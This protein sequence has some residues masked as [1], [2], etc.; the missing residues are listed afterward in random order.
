MP[1][2]PQG[3][4]HVLPGLHR[5]LISALR[6]AQEG[7]GLPGEWRPGVRR[8]GE[9]PPVQ[10]GTGERGVLDVH[11]DHE[12]CSEGVLTRRAVAGR[13]H[14]GDVALHDMRASRIPEDARPPEHSPYGFVARE[15]T[16]TCTLPVTVTAMRSVDEATRSPV[17]TDVLRVT[18][19]PSRPKNIL[20]FPS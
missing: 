1:S 14:T 16:W 3:C 6:R 15:R 18:H 12:N 17:I 9:T 11:G 19:T 10:V 8:G 20:C 2:I 7:H 5:V 13:R 4:G